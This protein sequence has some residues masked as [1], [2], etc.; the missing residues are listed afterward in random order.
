MIHDNAIRYALDIYYHDKAGWEG[1]VEN[2]MTADHSWR[3]TAIEYIE[4]YD[5]LAP[6]EDN[7]LC[8]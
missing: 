7:S 3:S 2:A 8:M 1:L 4:L 6:E 5:R